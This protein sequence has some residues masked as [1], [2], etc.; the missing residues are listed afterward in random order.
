MS[1]KAVLSFYIILL[2]LSAFGIGS[3]VTA[4]SRFYQQPPTLGVQA[5]LNDFKH[6]N[7]GN[8]FNG[9][10]KLKIGIAV[11]YVQGLTNK[12]DWAGT[13]S[14]SIIDFTSRKG[15]NYGQGNKELLFES[16]FSLRR[17]FV[18]CKIGFPF[19]QG[20]IGWSVYKKYWGAFI[21]AGTGF[22]F[23]I[24]KRTFIILNAQYR[25]SL[26]NTQ[27]DHFFYSV[28][29]S[30]IIGKAKKIKEQSEPISSLTNTPPKDTDG[31]GIADSEDKCI[32]VP[33]EITYKGCPV[34]DSDADGLTDDKDSC[35]SV[36]GLVKYDG[37]PVPDSD[38]DKVNDEVDQC[39]DIFG[40]PENKGCPVNKDSIAKKIDNAARNIFFITGSYELDTSSFKALDEVIKI[41]RENPVFNLDIEGHTDNAGT[42]ERNQLLS[43]QRAKAVYDYLNSKGI[44][45]FRLQAFG[46]GQARPVADNHTIEGRALNRRVK[47]ELK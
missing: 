7:G 28:G 9:F 2:L 41:L 46:Y 43:E 33:G 30:G 21:P 31:D 24:S 37:C 25:L 26:T 17:K 39:P 42:V 34:P 14:G 6:T 23:N 19:L 16:D 13:I 27:D 15:I 4:Q 11:N 29:I 5:S 47:M 18:P 10:S 44:P 40:I 20:G 8:A 45:R 22:Q 3:N 1:A 36:P 35:I 12:L 38:G 32:T